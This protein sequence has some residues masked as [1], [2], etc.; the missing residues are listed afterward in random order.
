MGGSEGGR[1]IGS[2]FEGQVRVLIICGRV[3]H[4]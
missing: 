3:M 2:E 1:R 4:E